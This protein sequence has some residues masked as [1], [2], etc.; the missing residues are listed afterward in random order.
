[1]DMLDPY[2][3]DE[4]EQP[5]QILLDR[6][7]AKSF[8]LSEANRSMT[9]ILLP[10]LDEL[11]QETDLLSAWQRPS[12]YERLVSR[13][14]LPEGHSLDHS[15]DLFAAIFRSRKEVPHA[16]VDIS[17]FSPASGEKIHLPPVRIPLIP[18]A[19]RFSGGRKTAD[20]VTVVSWIPSLA[21]AVKEPHWLVLNRFFGARKVHCVWC[22]PEQIRWFLTRH[23]DRIMITP[24]LPESAIAL[25]KE[26]TNGVGR[27]WI[28]LA[29][30]AL[31]EAL[32]KSL[33]ATLF[34]AVPV[35]WSEWM[36]TLAVSETLRR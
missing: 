1:M 26:Y 18:L 36:A 7:L 30:F 24:R 3:P 17:N 21:Q 22:D 20:E 34:K 14:E 16:A 13:F 12:F 23:A 11:A 10:Y 29:D 19:Y 33:T 15:T 35:Y 8:N 5:L 32:L 31:P 9:E 2:S 6:V 4:A 27:P 28:D 25:N